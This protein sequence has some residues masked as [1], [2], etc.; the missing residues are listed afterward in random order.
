M[1]TTVS[2][3]PTIAIETHG[4]KLNQADS[5]QLA[6]QFESAGCTVVDDQSQPDV[7]I[8]NTCTVTHVA[9]RKARQALRSAR[10]R[11]PTAT[12]VATGCY[13]ERAADDLQQ[14]EEVDLVLGNV[15]KPLLV[16][17]V[18]SLDAV[19]WTQTT[20]PEPLIAFGR[21]RSMVKIQEGCNQICAY[22][23]VPKVR[24]REVS[25]PPDEIISLINRNVA[26]G[27]KEIVLTGTQL[28]T[29]GFE[30]DDKT[31]LSVLIRR[32]L[33]DGKMSRLRVSSLQPQ[34][35]DSELLQ[36]WNDD[37]LAPH[38]HVPLQSGNNQILHRMRRRYTSS[39]YSK[40]LRQIRESVPNVAITTDVIV[41]F[42]GETEEQFQETYSLCD[43]SGFAAVH[44]FPYSARPGTSATYFPL[45]VDSETKASRVQQLLKLAEHH[46]H[47]FRTEMLNT[48][49]QVLWET[50]RS[51]GNWVGL[52]DNYVKV[53][54]SVA[55]NLTNQFQYAH[56]LKV[57]NDL[58]I[59]ELLN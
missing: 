48:A 17:Q 41:G 38:F 33:R 30:Y 6:S 40:V 13:P 12:I 10:R 32:I 4:C 37:R 46:S 42:P 35:I 54:V 29:Y 11:N 39:L 34:E 47:K 2:T 53:G 14:M 49:K 18:L 9:D 8:V 5:L 59:G 55:E 16:H 22:C 27:S 7:Y 15:D 24:G 31:T 20:N 1:F 52:T 3:A 58:V 44:V 23:I 28:G 43:A 19:N 26:K 45:H 56:L 57:E 25:I 36:L 51:D 50:K 21:T